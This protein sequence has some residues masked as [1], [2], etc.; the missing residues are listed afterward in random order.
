MSRK[1]NSAQWR[2]CV[3]IH[4]AQREP[5]VFTSYVDGDW[6]DVPNHHLITAEGLDHVFA[7]SREADIRKHLILTE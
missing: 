5:L 4:D 7:D 2:T 6:D 3:S 1:A